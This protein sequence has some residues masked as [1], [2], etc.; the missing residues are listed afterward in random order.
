MPNKKKQRTKPYAI[1]STITRKLLTEQQKTT[2]TIDQHS[3]VHDTSSSSSSSESSN[4]DNK[5]QSVNDSIKI[6][7]ANERRNKFRILA[8]T[9]D[10]LA[11]IDPSLDSTLYNKQLEIQCITTLVPLIR[12]IKSEPFEIKDHHY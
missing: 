4:V 8:R 9:L 6:M 11:N 1:K 2:S 7:K 12:Q 10:T 3:I 5:H